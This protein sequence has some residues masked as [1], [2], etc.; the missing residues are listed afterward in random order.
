MRR[1]RQGHGQWCRADR[2]TGTCSSP[3]G[4]TTIYARM[5]GDGFEAASSDDYCWLSRDVTVP[6]GGSVEAEGRYRLYDGRD[7]G[8]HRAVPPLRRPR[9]LEA[10]RAQKAEYNSTGRRTCPYIDVPKKAVQKAIDY[11]WWLERFNSLDANIP[12]YDYQYPVTIEG[13]LGYNNAIILT[14]PMHLQD[15]KWLRSPYP[16]LRPAAV[17]GQ[18]LAEQR[19]P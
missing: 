10:V 13:V 7:P 18:L 17:R 8:V 4:L 1:A 12:G 3:A 15:T 14:Q 5:T 16:G 11:R 6:A 9:N 19:L 2:L